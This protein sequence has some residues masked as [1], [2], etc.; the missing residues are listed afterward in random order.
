VHEVHPAVGRAA[1]GDVVEQ[2]QAALAQGRAD[3]LDVGHPERELLQTGA[4]APD[5]LRDRRVLV[6]RGQQL[7]ARLA[8]ADREHRLVHALLLVDL[9]VH[10]V[11]AEGEFVEGDGLAQV[12]HGDAHVVDGRQQAVGQTRAASVGAHAGIL[13]SGRPGRPLDVVR[14]TPGWSGRSAVLS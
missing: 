2:S 3:R 13:P 4:V 6:Q 5:E 14:L 9:L 12:G 10:R 7:D 11:H 1:L 8:V